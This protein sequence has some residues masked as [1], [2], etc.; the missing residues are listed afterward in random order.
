MLMETEFGF[1]MAQLGIA[2]HK[3][4]KDYKELLVVKEMLGRK[5]RQ[6]I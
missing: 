2:Y 5:E 4:H 3:D 1:G 6:A